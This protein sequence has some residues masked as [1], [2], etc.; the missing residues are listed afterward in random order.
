MREPDLSVV[1]PS[2][3]D[4]RELSLELRLFIETVACSSCR[5]SPRSS[6]SFSADS[7]G[8]KYERRVAGE[9]LALP[10]VA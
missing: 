4:L 5:M 8:P 7:E 9:A 1:Q 3:C 10:D 2:G 6:Q